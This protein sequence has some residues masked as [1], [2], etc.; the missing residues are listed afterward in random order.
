[1]L[2][3]VICICVPKKKKNLHFFKNTESGSFLTRIE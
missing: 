3:V 1:M 2:V